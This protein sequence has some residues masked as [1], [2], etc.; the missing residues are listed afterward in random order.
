MHVI[1][2]Y[3]LKYYV[4]DTSHSFII[5]VPR[6]QFQSDRIQVNETDEYVEAIIV[7]SGDVSGTVSVI[8]STRSLTATGSS[9][10]GLESG[11]DFV[12]RGRSNTNRVVFPPGVTHANCN[13]KV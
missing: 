1:L 8:C 3:F 12:S 13:V 9:L 10:T 5:S 4:D 11:S 2:N 6:L 7:R